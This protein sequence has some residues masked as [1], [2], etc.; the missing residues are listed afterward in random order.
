MTTPPHPTPPPARPSNNAPAAPPVARDRPFR[1]WAR[2]SRTGGALDPMP[3]SSTTPHSRLRTSRSPAM[4]RVLAAAV[5]AVLA[6][7]SPSRWASACSSRHRQRLHPSRRQLPPPAAPA[8]RPLGHRQPP[9]PHS[10]SPSAPGSACRRGGRSSPS[11]PPSRSPT[12]ATCPTATATPSACSSNAP[13][14]AGA[15]PRRSSTPPTPPRSSTRRC[16]PSPTGST[17]R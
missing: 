13:P 1:V 15:P 10:S 7:C 12:C 6:P 11:P 17:S 14:Q 9:T 5:A 2:A 8:V 4:T 16:S 3:P